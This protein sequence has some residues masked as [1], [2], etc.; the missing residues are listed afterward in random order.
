MRV[1]L[2]VHLSVRQ[3]V[4]ESVVYPSMR[5]VNARKTMGILSQE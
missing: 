2:P 1:G 4:L 3:F 5:R